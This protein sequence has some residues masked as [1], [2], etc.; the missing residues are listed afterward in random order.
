MRKRKSFLN[1]ASESQTHTKMNNR[2]NILNNA[3]REL[4]SAIKSDKELS[5]KEREELSEM[6]KKAYL[7]KKIGYFMNDRISR[8]MEGQPIKPFQQIPSL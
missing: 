3:Y 4:L 7:R 1:F 6:A 5:E 2:I 8:I